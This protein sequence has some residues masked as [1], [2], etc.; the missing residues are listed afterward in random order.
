LMP[1]A[2]ARVYGNLGQPNHFA[3]YL[4]LGLVSAVYLAVTRR[5]S[6]FAAA[7]AALLLLVLLDF[8]G[9]RSAWLYLLVAAA[10]AVAMHAGIR[11]PQTKRALLWTCAL[12][13][14]FGLVQWGAPL[15]A[16][17][18]YDV[19]STAGGRLA[20]EQAG[21]PI[22]LQR[23][24]AALLM[25]REA[26]LLGAGFGSFAWHRFL[27]GGALGRNLEPAV[28]D[29][30]H[31]IAFQVL[32]EFGL[33]GGA[34]AVLAAVFWLDSQRRV[35]PCVEKWWALVLLATIAVHSLFEY[36]LWY[37]YFLGAFCLALGAAEDRP[38]RF[39]STALDRSAFLGATV[40]AA[41]VLTTVPIDYRRLEELT[42][43]PR[44]AQRQEQL[45]ALHGKS[46]FT[47]LVEFDLSRTILP[48]ESHLAD[49]IALNGRA[50]RY[51]PKADVVYRQS[52]LLA[53][54]GRR[55]EAFRQW[56]LAAAAFPGEREA[57]IGLLRDLDSQGRAGVRP[58]VEYAASRSKE[59]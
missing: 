6:T 5:L 2:S 50:M 3:D 36:P 22:R 21:V 7:M 4:F 38:W 26:P 13:A 12:L 31:N 20:A 33:A 42:L 41:W 10:L 45:L 35:A 9:S 15:V 19:A 1:L 53:L 25:W 49:K 34:L 55:D 48:D 14:A 28:A 16:P 54:D 43:A 32:A 51:L 27:Q 46:L 18:R 17:D 24:H 8:S 23:W 40:L 30:A 47:N 57:A 52:L 59:P 37:A 58:L 56:D 39:R 11:S 29:N 44:T